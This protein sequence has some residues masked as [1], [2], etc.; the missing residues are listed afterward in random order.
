VGEVGW[1]SEAGP[2]P[3]RRFK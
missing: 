2:D 3:R 1:C